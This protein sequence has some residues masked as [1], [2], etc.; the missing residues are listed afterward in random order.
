MR[1][2]EI[3]LE[4][5]QLE[6]PDQHPD[7]ATYRTVTFRVL[8]AGHPNSFLVPISVNLDQYGPDEVEDQARFV[9]HRL[10]QALAEA[11]QGWNR[12]LPGDTPQ[13]TNVR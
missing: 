5:V 4:S 12:A 1:T 3:R 11:T 2:E 8:P 13:A 9:F 6:W 10:A 7:L